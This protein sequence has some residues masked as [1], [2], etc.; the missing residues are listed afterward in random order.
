MPLPQA[1]SNS[2]AA[3]DELKKK[4]CRYCDARLSKPFLELG[5]MPLANSFLTKGQMRESEFACPLALA[6]CSHC[7]LV[8]LTHVVPADLMFSNYLYV[9]STTQTFRVHFAEYAKTVRQKLGDRKKKAVAVDIGSNDGL[10][11]ACYEEEGLTGIGI[12]PAKNLSDE[13][14]RQGRRTINRYFDAAC[15]DQILREYGPASAISANNVFAHM[16]DTRSV[17][18]HITRLLDPKGMA[19]I[20]FPYLLTML[21]DMLFDMIYHEHLSYIAATPLV[22]VLNRFGLEIFDIDTVSSHGGSL[23]VFIQKKG[24][25]FKIEAKVSDYFEREKKYL[26]PRA[27][28]H[29]AKQVHQVKKDLTDFVEQARREGK[30]ISGYGAPAKASTIINFCKFSPS[31]IAYIV[32]DNP[33]KQNRWMPGAKIPIVPSAYLNGHPTHYVILFAWNFAKEIMAKSGHLKE[34]GVRFLIPLP[35]PTLV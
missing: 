11:V 23:R 35:K 17:L 25:P 31:Q 21:E 19:V 30:S 1:K 12:E 27:Y 16:D 10:L 13:A 33:L 24:G 26:T 9:S 15:V 18:T 29:F 2:S 4:A 14:A 20:E 34:K 28:E 8:Q 22:F 6:L 3:A 5:A 32:D 7:G